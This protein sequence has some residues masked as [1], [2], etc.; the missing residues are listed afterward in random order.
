VSALTP[1]WGTVLIRP[2][3]AGLASGSVQVPTARGEVSVAFTRSGTRFTAEVDVPAT[4]TAEVALPGVRA[5]QR[6]WVDGT[7]QVASA[8]PPGAAQPGAAVAGL[9]VVT[10][11]SGWHR[12]STAP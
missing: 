7:P 5:G 11:G 4:A 1:G 10:V 8:L 3:P 12:V 9:A 2:Q 6:V